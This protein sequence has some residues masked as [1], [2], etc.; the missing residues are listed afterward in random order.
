MEF[1]VTQNKLKT[2]SMNKL[3]VIG[4]R[5][6][7]WCFL[8]VPKEEAIKKYMDIEWPELRKEHPDSSYMD[9]EELLETFTG[10]SIDEIEFDDCFQAD[11]VSPFVPN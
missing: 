6:L 1:F 5:G 7:E 8:N 11:T 2:L 9:D 4:I 3:I 10:G